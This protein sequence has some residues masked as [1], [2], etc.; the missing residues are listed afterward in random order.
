MR[1]EHHMN[2][3]TDKLLTILTKLAADL[4]RTPTRREMDER[5]GTPDSGTY[6][7]AFGSW[8]DA[9]RKAGL[10]PGRRASISDDELLSTLCA[11]A[12]DLGYTPTIADMRTRDDVPSVS[13]YQS[14]FGSWSQAHQEA[15]LE[16]RTQEIHTD[17][18]LLEGI[19]DLAAKV[20]GQPTA[21]QMDE[22]GP[23]A[24]SVYQRAFGS[25]TA[26][27]QEAG[28]DPIQ[29]RYADEELLDALHQ[30]TTDLGH[31]PQVTDAMKHD[32][33]PSLQVYYGRF[34]SWENALEQAGVELPPSREFTNDELLTELHK[35]AADLGR[36]PTMKEM[37]INEDTPSATV[38]K[39]HF[40]SWNEALQ[41][42]GLESV[43]RDH[44]TDE[45][46]LDALRE[47]ATVLDKTPTMNEMQE[48]NGFPSTTVYQ[49]R[50]G[51][52]NAAVRKAGL[53]PN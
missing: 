27:L 15:G 10:K 4:G 5:D 38:Y 1:K 41:E 18:T 22:R 32:D 13:T 24:V 20:G 26:A 48:Y 51:S 53:E 46:L 39:G 33:F 45:E 40:G 29:Y 37:Q 3:S 49:N 31:S 47:V 19:A 35:L 28:F 43:K 17:G 25:W 34:G 12:A 42:A 16:P 7:R 6:R 50:F 11:V 23:Y 9:L 36:T 52:W 44:Y 14:R 8:N 2:Y 30:I 21:D